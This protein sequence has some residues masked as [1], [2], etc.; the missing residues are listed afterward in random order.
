MQVKQYRNHTRSYDDSKNLC[1]GNFQ[2]HENY[3]YEEYLLKKYD[4]PKDIAL[5]FGCGMGRMMNRML[6]IFT[7]VDGAD[8]MHENIDY[9]RYFLSSENNIPAERYCLFKTDGI[10]CDLG[11]REVYDFVYSTICLQHISIHSIRFR[12]ICDIYELLK[13]GGQF[14]LQ[15]G[16]GW[17]NGIYWKDNM[18]AARYTNA[19][20]DVSIPNHRHLEILLE[21]FNRIGFSDVTW[22]IAES[23]HG[24]SLKYHPNF[25]YFYLNK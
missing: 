8:L 1:V 21:E 9:A 2:D 13:P 17:D 6:N 4:G 24:T 5:D 25:I 16:F 12:I 10:G 15:L 18:Y 20:A 19:G 11:V 7:R 23:P 22:E 14:C 3:P